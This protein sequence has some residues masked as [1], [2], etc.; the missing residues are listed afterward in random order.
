[1]TGHAKG[2]QMLFC[3]PHQTKYLVDNTKYSL[4]YPNPVAKKLFVLFWKGMLHP[5]ADASG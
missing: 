4:N 2:L 5:A 1:M 3:H